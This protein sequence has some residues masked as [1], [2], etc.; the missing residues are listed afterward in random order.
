MIV[1]CGF[2]IAVRQVFA[3][4]LYRHATDGTFLGGFTRQDLQRPFVAIAAGCGRDRARVTAGDR[5]G[6]WTGVR[7]ARRRIPVRGPSL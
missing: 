6:R 5:G 2:A 4:A 1:L 3:V 7:H